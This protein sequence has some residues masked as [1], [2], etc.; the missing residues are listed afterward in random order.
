MTTSL[1]ALAEQLTG[2]GHALQGPLYF[3]YEGELLTE[4]RDRTEL[5]GEERPCC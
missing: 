3:S 1:S 2:L 4:R 5:T